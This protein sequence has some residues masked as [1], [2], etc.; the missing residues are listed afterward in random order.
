MNKELTRLVKHSGI[1][2]LGTA[3]SKSVGFIMIPVYTRFL[4]PKD[5]GIL[6]LLDL[7]LFV[8]TTFAAMGIYGAIFRFYAA[9]ESEKDKKEVIATALLYS[10]TASLLVGLALICWGF[11]IAGVLL[12]NTSLGPLVRI[13]GCTFFFSNLTEAPMAYWRAQGRTTLFVCVGLVRTL[14]AATSLAFFLAILKM[15]IRGALYANLVTNIVWGVTL[16]GIVLASVPWRI[17]KEKL[18]KMLRYGLP[19]VAWSI[20]GFILTF[21][22]RLFLRYYASLSEVGVYALGYKLAGIVSIA[23]TAPF[24]MAWQWQQFE[25][26]KRQDAKAIFARVE[27]Y[28][29]M[30]TTLVALGVSVLAKDMLRI[31]VPETFWPAAYVVPLIAASYLLFNMQYVVISG[32][33]INHVTS[34]LA[35]VAAIT[36]GANLALNYLLIPRFHAMGAAVA[37]WLSYAFQLTLSFIAAQITYRVAY[38]YKRNAMI[39]GS[40]ISIYFLSR[41][42]QLGISASVVFNLALIMLFS[43]VCYLLLGAE[44]RQMAHQWAH[45]AGS[46]LRRAWL[47]SRQSAA[48]R[49]PK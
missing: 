34:R 24:S 38:E 40:A 6:E 33:Y 31:M 26:A 3:L 2:G 43:G 7:A 49:S 21:S 36:A 23:I 16:S 41:F 37:T 10:S 42:P 25:L 20:A 8:S 44:E 5:Y 14:T 12:G 17:S 28:L 27:T 13:V 35:I 15:G 4:T 18:T 30:V 47:Q 32:I 45:A 46:G 11:P 22:D 1:Y 9:Y 48:L 19:T 39:L 29:L